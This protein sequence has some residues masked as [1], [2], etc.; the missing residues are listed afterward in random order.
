[1]QDMRVSLVHDEVKMKE[2]NYVAKIINHVWISGM[3]L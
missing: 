2:H 1:M 3:F